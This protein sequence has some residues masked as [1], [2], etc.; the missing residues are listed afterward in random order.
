MAYSDSTRHRSHW[1]GRLAAAM[2]IWSRHQRPDWMEIWAGCLRRIHAWRVP[3]HW[4]ARDWSEEMQA[5][6]A[7][8]AVQAVCEYDGARESH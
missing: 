1:D 2:T 3:P 7:A 5:H 8:A 4:S 6:C